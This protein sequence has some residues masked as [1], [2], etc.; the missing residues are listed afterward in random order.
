[1]QKVSN[2]ELIFEISIDKIGL[3]YF[4]SAI[5]PEKIEE[6]TG[7]PVTEEQIAENDDGLINRLLVCRQ[8]ENRFNP[9][10][11][12]FTQL[13]Y[14]NIVKKSNDDLKMDTCNFVAFENQKWLWL[15]FVI[16]NVC[17]AS[18]SRYDQW[19]LPEEHEEYLRS[20]IDKTLYG[21]L[22]A[23]RRRTDEFAEEIENDRGVEGIGIFL[24]NTKETG[25]VQNLRYSY[26]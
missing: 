14:A 22:D 21:D 10:E 23:I 2:K 19:C 25:N 18:A 13:I 20:F 8:C 17:R 26:D 12:A 24:D 7:T 16:I 9:I 5:Q 11:T 4:G 1:L 6:V 3:D 15:Q